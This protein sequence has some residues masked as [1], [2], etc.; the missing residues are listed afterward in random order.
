MEATTTLTWGDTEKILDN[1][2]RMANIVVG[3]LKAVSATIGGPL[4]FAIALGIEIA[5]VGAKVVQAEVSDIP[6]RGEEL[7][8]EAMW[9]TV[10]L[11]GGVISDGVVIGKLNDAV[12]K[13]R[14]LRLANKKII[15]APRPKPPGPHAGQRALPHP[16][17]EKNG[18]SIVQQVVGK[19]DVQATNFTQ[20]YSRQ[21]KNQDHTQTLPPANAMGR[22][23]I[24]LVR[25]NLQASF[26]FAGSAAAGILG[27]L[28]SPGS[29]LTPE[30]AGDDVSVDA[31]ACKTL[32]QDTTDVA[33]AVGEVFDDPD[34]NYDLEIIQEFFFGRGN[35]IT[36]A[37]FNQ[38]KD[39]LSGYKDNATP[40]QLQHLYRKGQLKEPLPESIPKVLRRIAIQRFDQFVLFMGTKTTEPMA[41]RRNLYDIQRENLENY[42]NGAYTYANKSRAFLANTIMHIDGALNSMS[43]IDGKQNDIIQDSCFGKG[44]H[45]SKAEMVQAKD[46]LLS[47]KNTASE[48]ELRS[49]YNSGRFPVNF[50]DNTANVPQLPG[51]FKRISIVNFEMFVLWMDS[52]NSD[53][54]R[55]DG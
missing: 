50:T 31:Q 9:D 7:R 2:M 21:F 37:E 53:L 25:Q 27:P 42:L 26:V 10:F 40:A 19:H 20:I 32:L 22:T 54:G 44:N 16:L 48:V 18:S 43:H 23:I 52:R 12:K 39:F 28:A 1:I 24:E 17:P 35:Y 3:P 49:F 29:G 41:F 13:Y 38:I 34:M 14:S 33:G 36:K 8:S 46:F 6:S 47:F 15:S 51:V 30:G 11:V 4:G 45:I 55:L 5:Y